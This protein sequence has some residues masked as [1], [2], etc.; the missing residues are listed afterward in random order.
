MKGR[1]LALTV[2]VYLTLDLA[3]PFIPGVVTFVDGGL[4]V[5]DAGRPPGPDLPMP[6]GTGEASAPRGEPAVVRRSPRPS[7]AAMH[8]RRWWIPARRVFSIAPEP[9]RSSDDH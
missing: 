1:I 9:G 2:L 5:I 4:E 3:N 7:T 8:P 6:D